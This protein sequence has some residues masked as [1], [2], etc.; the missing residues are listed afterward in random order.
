MKRRP[1]TDPRDARILRHLQQSGSV[2]AEELCSLLEV[3]IATVRRDLQEL[4]N[5]GLL[6]RT[7]GGAMTVEPL[8]YEPFRHD[9][10]FREQIEQHADEKRRIAMAASDLIQ[11]GE[12]I[13]L[14]AGTTTT[15]V[16]RSIRYRSGITVVTNTVNVAMELSQ[17]RDLEVV[18]TGGYLRGNWFSLVG[19]LATQALEQIYVDKVFIGANGA[20]AERGLTCHNAD[21]AGTNRVMVGHAK[22]KIA[23]VDHSK[24]GV[25]ATHRICGFDAVDLLI[26]D[27]GATDEALAPFLALGL[28]VRR[29]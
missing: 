12:T 24:L 11:D 4:E 9:S 26:T 3:S 2:S 6:R 18:V 21:E 28:D 7:H 27:T 5:R 19:P 13:S 20:D 15:E 10:S 25:V 29:V 1:G 22:K 14:T 8:L 17:R 16:V 23:V